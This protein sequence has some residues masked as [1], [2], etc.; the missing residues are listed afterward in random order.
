MNDFPFDYMKI[1]QCYVNHNIKYLPRQRMKR[2]VV[3]QAMND[4]YEV[5]MICVERLANKVFISL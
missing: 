3:F 5:L 1:K 2:K 4:L